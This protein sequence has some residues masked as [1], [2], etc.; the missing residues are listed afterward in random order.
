VAL[1]YD[2]HCTEIV[3]QTELLRSE[4]VS[5]DL[6]TPVPSC[7]GWNVGQLVRHL[8]GGQRW[9]AAAVG[10]QVHEPLAEDEFAM[11]DLSA[12]IAED[13]ATLG[14]W[15]VEG[16]EELATALRAAGAGVTMWTPVP[17]T[18]TTDFYARRFAHET[19]MHGADATLALGDD[20]DADPVV[21]ADAIDEWFELGSLPVMF[22]YH[23]EMRELLGRDL[24]WA[25]V[26]PRH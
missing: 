25:S 26:D 9:A 20:F 6:T 16:A 13:P 8:G 5:R 2:R 7:P 18:S 17:S 11:R 19:L 12:C 21:V 22:E 15:L 3:A 23:P 24:A 14:P 4:I 1:E 10:G